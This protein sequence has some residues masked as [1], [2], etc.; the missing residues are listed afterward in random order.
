MELDAC[1]VSSLEFWALTEEPILAYVTPL[2][3]ESIVAAHIS[4]PEV[5]QMYY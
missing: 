4:L 2:L 5:I 1:N 3:S